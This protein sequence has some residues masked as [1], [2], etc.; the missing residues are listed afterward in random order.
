VV[1][2]AG[3]DAATF[4]Y[5]ERGYARDASRVYFEGTA[6]A[7]AMLRRSRSSTTRSRAT[8][9]PRIAHGAHRGSDAATFT[10]LDSH[11]AKDRVRVYWCGIETDGG[12]RPP[13]VQVVALDADVGSFAPVDATGEDTD[14]KDARGAFKRGRRVR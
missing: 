11:Y 5:M 4:R 9:R 13:Y 1:E 3:A 14:A 8:R 7:V 2:I 10:V 12:A 6:H